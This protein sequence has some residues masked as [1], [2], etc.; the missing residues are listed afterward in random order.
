MPVRNLLLVMYG[1][2]VGRVTQTSATAEPEF[3]YEPAYLATGSTPLGVRMP[4]ADTTYRGASVRAFL[5]G[6]LPE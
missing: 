1:G 3:T 5:E 4:L 6:V 2:V